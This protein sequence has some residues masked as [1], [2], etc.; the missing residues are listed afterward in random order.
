ML[1]CVNISD[2]DGCIQF[3]WLLYIIGKVCMNV[4]FC[5][6][7]IY[8]NSESWRVFLAFISQLSCSHKHRNRTDTLPSQLTSKCE[9]LCVFSKVLTKFRCGFELEQQDKSSASCCNC[10]LSCSSF[11]SEK[12][13]FL[14]LL[15]FSSLFPAPLSVL[16]SFHLS[17][18]QNVPKL[19]FRLIHLHQALPAR[20]NNTAALLQHCSVTS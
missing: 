6:I 14:C 20:T 5:F 3:E 9:Q 8:I 18:V 11:P 19:L 1:T 17:A 2:S 15:L 12:R 7:R 10:F 4:F 16:S 13:S